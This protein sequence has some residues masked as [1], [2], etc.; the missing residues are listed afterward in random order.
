MSGGK[1][2]DRSAVEDVAEIV[3]K[4]GW[5][6]AVAES[7]TGGLLSNQ[8]ARGPNAG[9]WFR[10]G[11]VAY[12]RTAK[13][14]ILGVPEGP[15]VSETAARHMARGAS[16]LFHARCTM[17]VTGAGG[18]SGQDGA[19]PGTVWFAWRVEDL[20]VAERHELDGGPE[21]V[22]AGV[23]ELAIGRL[24]DLLRERLAGDGGGGSGPA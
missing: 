11:L 8:L 19:P 9:S 22:C 3:E 21:A 17:A 14:D 16:A 13:Y 12:D 5:E 10:G 23:C 7:L 24:R 15:V 18:P 6:V 2:D 4:L 1:P 20:E